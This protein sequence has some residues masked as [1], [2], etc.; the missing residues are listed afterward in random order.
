[1]HTLSSASSAVHRPAGNGVVVSVPGING[2][3]LIANGHAIGTVSVPRTHTSTP[4]PAPAL[5]T[6]AAATQP[7]YAGGV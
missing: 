6:S 1:M 7:V 5:S 4:L 3:D 2:A